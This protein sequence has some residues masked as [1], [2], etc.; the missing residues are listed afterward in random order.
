MK[1]HKNELE[2]TQD[3]RARISAIYLAI[4]MA[5]IPLFNLNIGG[6]GLFLYLGV[7]IILTFLTIHRYTTIRGVRLLYIVFVFFDLL[8]ILWGK[9]ISSGDIF[10]WAKTIFFVISISY[11]VLNTKELKCVY[12]FQILMGLVVAIVLCTTK[13]TMVIQG[14]WLTDTGRSILVV[15]GV[16]IDPNYTAILMIPAAC[17]FFKKLLQRKSRLIITVASFLGL[18]LIFFALFRSGTRGG[19]LAVVSSLLFYYIRDTQAGVKKIVWLFLGVAAVVIAFP[20]LMSLLP[21]NI[22]RRFTLDMMFESGGS[23]RIDF[24][25]IILGNVF[26]SPFAFLFGH[27]YNAALNLLGIAS[28]NYF[29]DVLY[30]GGLVR[31]ILLLL[32]YKSMFKTAYQNGNLFVQAILV[33]YIVMSC[34]VSV[35]NNMFFWNGMVLVILLGEKEEIEL[36]VKGVKSI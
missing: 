20:A 13:D 26:S 16:Q 3:N 9:D 23:G 10:Q 33:A 18:I 28:H 22:A 19:L 12:L 21:D 11:A 32:L 27:G 2:A 29:I 36:G 17:F 15:G 35:G 5:L 30:N 31:L 25:K 8:T 24:W 4:I 1:N 6:R 7:G 34:S 14:E